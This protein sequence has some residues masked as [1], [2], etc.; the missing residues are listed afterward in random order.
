M[1]TY[2]RTTRPALMAA[3]IFAASTLVAH[4]Q[5]APAGGRGGRGPQSP[6]LL[7]TTTAFEDGGVVP[8]KYTQAAGPNAVSPA[9]SWS[10]VPPGT[11]SFAL[12]MHDPEPVLNR[13]SKMDIT[14]WVVWNIPATSAGLPEGVPAGELPDGTRQVSLRS[15]GYM[16]PGAPPGPYHHYTFELY[17]L[18]IKLEVPQGTPQQASDTRTAVVNAMDGH[19]LGKAVLIGRFHR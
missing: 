9:L 17:A 14:H 18:D 16:G 12:I 1:T 3:V 8:D 7:M 5:G 19:V 10:Q 2:V 6:P 13:G 4:A 15:N 11:Q